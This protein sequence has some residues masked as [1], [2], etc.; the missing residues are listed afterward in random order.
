MEKNSLSPADIAALS[1]NNDS[2]GNNGA[3]WLILFMMFAFGGNGWGN[4]WGNNGWNNNID[5]RFLER[6]VFATNQNVSNTGA[7]TNQNVSNSACQT[8]RDVLENRYTNQLGIQQ[9][10]ANDNNCCMQTQ[11]QILNSKYDLD[12]EILQN[13]Y[14]NSLQTQTLSGQL[15]QCCCDIKNT[16][17][18]EGEATRALITQNMIDNLRDQLAAARVRVWLKLSAAG[19]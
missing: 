5:N 13:R 7:F 8:Q 4:G 11:N 19:L 2:F 1:G 15:A 18:Q 6:D 17:H 14:E 3:W 10:I 16:T 12:K 9:V